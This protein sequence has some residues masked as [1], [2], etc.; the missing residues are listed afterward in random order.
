MLV[1]ESGSGKSSNIK[2]HTLSIRTTQ[3]II[4]GHHILYN[5][6]SNH[7][8]VVLCCMRYCNIVECNLM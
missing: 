1:G 4:K 3:N 6:I 2:V 7:F 8:Y 5:L